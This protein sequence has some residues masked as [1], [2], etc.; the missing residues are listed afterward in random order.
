MK[1]LHITADNP[2]D[3][4]LNGYST[5]A[6]RRVEIPFEWVH[7]ADIDKL[8]FLAARLEEMTPAQLD[9]IN[10]FMQTD[11][12]LDSLDKLIDYTYNTDYFVYIPE[13]YPVLIW[14]I[15]T[16]MKAAWCKCRRNGKQA[17]TRRTSEAT[18]PFA[19]TGGLPTT[20]IS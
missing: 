14:E 1:A 17:L 4:F 7:E 19:K 6:G 5:E 12:K 2:Q 18:L 10:A 16:S 8:N 15:I 13:V 11:F 9:K 20:A 3:F